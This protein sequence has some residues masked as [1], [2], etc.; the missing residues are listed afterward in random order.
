MG[1]DLA[2]FGESFAVFSW[3]LREMIHHVVGGKKKGE[4]SKERKVRRKNIETRSSSNSSSE[5]C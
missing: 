2:N 5:F 1:L 3:L 4:K